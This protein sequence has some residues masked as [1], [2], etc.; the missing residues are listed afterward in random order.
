MASTGPLA[1]ERCGR[2]VTAEAG[3]PQHRG[4]RLLD[5]QRPEDRAWRQGVL[6]LQ[7]QRRW[8]L[9]ATLL[10]AGGMAAALYLLTNLISAGAVDQLQGAVGV[11]GTL[12]TILSGFSGLLVA[13]GVTW[14]TV[15][16]VTALRKI[17]QATDSI[18]QQAASRE[19][20]RRVTACTASIIFAVSIAALRDR[21]IG[22]PAELVAAATALVLIPP[23]QSMLDYLVEHWFR[24]P[25]VLHET[26]TL[27][28]PVED[29]IPGDT[30]EQDPLERLRKGAFR[31]TIMDR[32]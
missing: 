6:N 2:L 27:L 5:L 22:V 3:C 14:G 29:H 9:G 30:R 18:E 13:G 15:G 31:K 16:A 20:V 32:R 8:R 17:R 23:L 28:P 7:R 12:R 24:T 1:C 25:A 19:V 4:S 10:A 21:L 26:T 11:A